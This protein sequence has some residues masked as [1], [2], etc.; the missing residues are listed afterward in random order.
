[1]QNLVK[2]LKNLKQDIIQLVE[3]LETID[4]K[5][6]ELERKPDPKE[7]SD[8]RKELRAFI[9]IKADAMESR[10]NKIFK[11]IFGV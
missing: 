8:L 1:M 2:E 9:G 7:I 11:E 5:L 6:A 4:A 3:I 10:I